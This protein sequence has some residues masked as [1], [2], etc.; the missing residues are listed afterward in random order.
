MFSSLRYNVSR[1]IGA[2]IVKAI[3]A[4]IKSD[5]QE[6]FNSIDG[7]ILQSVNA[8]F[9][10]RNLNEF[11]NFLQLVE[12]YYIVASSENKQNETSQ[13]ILNRCSKR[14]SEIMFLPNYD[15]EKASDDKKE[16]IN[17]YKYQ[18]FRSFNSIFYETVKNKDLTYFKR[19][20]EQL[21]LSFFG[22]NPDLY[23]L[24][25]NLVDAP[26]VEIGRKL[27]ID[28]K[29]KIFY[30][31]ILLGI[32]YWIYF[33]YE[34]GEI[35]IDLMEKFLEELKK[36][37]KINTFFWE[38]EYLF[39]EL[40]SIK[41]LTLFDWNAWDYKERKEGKSHELPS[42]I[43]WIIRGYAIDSLSKHN[44]SVIN[45][46]SEIIS[47]D[48]E[49]RQ[50]I[51]SLLQQEIHKI[52]F[53]EKWLQYLGE[54]D[55]SNIINQIERLQSPLLN[56]KASEI[57]QAEL[58]QELVERFKKDAL[59][60][61]KKNQNVRAIFSHFGK[62][63]KYLGKKCL[64]SH[65]RQIYFENGKSLFI[66][67]E[68]HISIGGAE[69]FV[70]QMNID[71]ETDFIKLVS[72]S[73]I[74]VVYRS[75]TQGIEDS[76]K[77][78]KGFEVNAIL[79][80]HNLLY[81]N[82]FKNLLKESESFPIYSFGNIPVFTIKNSSFS[83]SFI[84]ANFQEAFIMLYQTYG[85]SHGEEELNV[86]VNEIPEEI[87]KEKLL[88]IQNYNMT[89]QDKRNIVMSSVVFDFEVLADFKIKNIGAFT[90]GY[91]EDL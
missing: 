54:I 91:V 90:I 61:W 71:E 17:A 6:S 15:F 1:E 50:L 57:A 77:K 27:L 45:F 28:N 30:N 73:K 85:K 9:R 5:A 26:T 42:V 63:K 84:V 32:R 74:P 47:D 48:S 31:Q 67:G 62:K 82:G 56:K 69:D 60:A 13:E 14:L 59:A 25:D 38:I 66:E 24:S 4:S 29:D 64:K 51:I 87:L 2:N 65:H 23:P 19:N 55:Q 39:S 70:R 43:K 68:H 46:N 8:F 83:N 52:K 11:I 35:K 20:I 37:K 78:I 12:K 81:V 44:L 10:K 7:F 88:N 80:D 34:N 16:E 3:K 36:A 41:G 33:L 79:I 21:D 22:E 72:E 75:L 40:N 49:N 76:I 53:N 58:D 89:E 18:I 86:E